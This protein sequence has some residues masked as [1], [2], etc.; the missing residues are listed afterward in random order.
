[1]SIAAPERVPQQRRTR[2]VR[3]GARPQRPAGRVPAPT[4]SPDLLSVR[5]AVAGDA[6]LVVLSGELDLG[7]S[8]RLMATVEAC[9]HGR[10]VR[11]VSID[12]SDVTFCD[13]CGVNAL[14]RVR[15]RLSENG[16]TIRLLDPS[17]SVTRLL[18]LLKRVG[19][20]PDA[21]ARGNADEPS[22]PWL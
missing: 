1:M 6:V 9:T 13:C 18:I 15:N 10:R 2:R 11:E 7:T 20:L 5:T 8:S 22:G 3:H 21:E 17:P 4:G 12:M 19:A 16:T 14:L